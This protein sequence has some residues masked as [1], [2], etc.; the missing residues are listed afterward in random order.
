MG[1]ETGSGG[2]GGSVTVGDGGGRAEEG[3]WSTGTGEQ[4]DGALCGGSPGS[5]SAVWYS[6]TV[7]QIWRGDACWPRSWVTLPR[8][9]AGLPDPLAPPT[10]D[11]RGAPGLSG[12]EHVVLGG[13][14]EL[15]PRLRP[16]GG[17][18]HLPANL[19]LQ[20]LDLGAHEWAGSASPVRAPAPGAA[21]APQP[22]GCQLICSAVPGAPQ[23]PYPGRGRRCSPIPTG[24]GGARCSIKQSSYPAASFL[25]LGGPSLP[26]ALQR[27]MTG[28]DGSGRG[29]AVRSSIAKCPEAQ[30]RLYA[31]VRGGSCGK[32]RERVCRDD[33]GVG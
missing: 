24:R 6:G 17:P 26:G 9:T 20:T 13:N 4:E 33:I 22:P 27:E 16:E 15:G 30:D 2:R 29:E 28:P 31:E 7:G 19:R 14:G 3:G 18:A 11:E 1:E 21:A 32:Q 10:G 23:P 5:L 25:G 12:G 8:A